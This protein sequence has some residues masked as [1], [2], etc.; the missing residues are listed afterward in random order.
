MYGIIYG[1]IAY[2]CIQYGIW[3][4]HIETELLL[5][6]IEVLPVFI[7]IKILSKHL[8]IEFSTTYVWLLL[9][10]LWTA[11]HKIE[12]SSVYLLSCRLNDLKDLKNYIST[13][14]SEWQR[15]HFLVR[16]WSLGLTDMTSTIAPHFHKWENALKII[17]SVQFRVTAPAAGVAESARGWWGP[18]AADSAV[19]PARLLCYLAS[20][21]WQQRGQL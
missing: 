13:H 4:Y 7:F 3:V 8:F 1:Y 6:G 15:A 10:W 21:R 14:C 11:R 19:S 12:T 9:H 5:N 16:L 18:D 2:L 17:L 20:T